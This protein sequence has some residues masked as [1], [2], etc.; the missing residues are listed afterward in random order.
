MTRKKKNLS[1]RALHCSQG[2]NLTVYSFFLPG[3]LITEIADIS[4]VDRDGDFNLEGFQRKAIKAH[5]KQI[6][7]YLNQGDVLFPN[8]I[9]LAFSPQIKFKKT[10]G[11]E[12][13]GISH[14][15]DAGTLTIPFRTDGQCVAWIV[16]G[17][18][19]SLALAQC[20]KRDFPVPVVGFVAPELS[21]Q[22]EQFILVNKA[23]PLP[24]RLINELLP[25]VDTRLPADLALRKVP[26]AIVQ[27]LHKDP[28]SPF[29]G[30]IKFESQRGNKYA[31]VNDSA[32]IQAIQHSI[33]NPL[34]ALA[35]YREYGAQAADIQGMYEILAMYWTLV[36]EVF[37]EAWGKPLAKSK[38]MHGAGI[39]AMGTLLDHIM[40][41]TYG[42]ADPRTV[43]SKSLNR[44]KPRCAW[45]SGTWE[46]I[47]YRWNQIQN[48][49]K[50]VKE[51][52]DQLIRLD[53]E[54]S[55]RSAS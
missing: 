7:D 1:V 21:V 43:I 47:G 40:P 45:T 54:A 12:P 53:Y 9:I 34:G 28:G 26:A 5:I 41:R 49:P 14:I 33:K 50:H 23:K 6:A 4:R 11:A 35:Q 31:I 19:R 13:K 51:L 37:P 27:L 24:T 46:D 55:K 48:T 17:Q 32:L 2:E 30:L 18:Q 36:A 16:D 39:K 22:R 3:H 20:E 8:A 15:A 52:S 44:I 29:N 38:L 42:S 10:R 25:E